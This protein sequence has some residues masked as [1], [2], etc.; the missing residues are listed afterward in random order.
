M[1]DRAA[2]PRPTANVRAEEAVIGKIIGSAESYWAIAGLLNAE[3]FTGEHHRQIFNAV[4][5]CCDT[6]SGPSMS[7]LEAWLPVSWEGVGEVEPVLQILLEKAA[8]VGSATDFVDEILAAWRERERI[9]IGK[10]ANQPAKTFEETR[11]A[12]EARF[13]V[14]D[15]S[16]RAKHA[17]HVGESADG[18]LRKSAEAYQHK[19]RRT[20]GV[21]TGIPEIDKMIGPLPPGTVVTL[22]AQSGHG[23]SALLAQILRNNAAPSLD[24]SS[25]HPSLFLSMEMSRDQNGYRN[26]SSM[27]GV[28]V[29]KQIKGDFNEK[30][31][32]DLMRAKKSL[33]QMP[34]YIQD[35][36]R[37]TVRQIGAECRAAHRR[38]GIGLFGIDHLRLVE[39][40]R[41]HWT[42]IRTIEY[43]T[44]YTKD[45]A[46][47][48]NAVIFQLAQ[49]T[50]EDSKTGNW[51]F[52]DSAI[53]GGGMVKANSD[54]VI[55]LA[56]PI[57]WLRQ[58]QPE[59]P[60]DANPKGRE[61]FDKWLKD[62]ETWRDKAEVAALK[63]R[64]GPSGSWKELEFHG[65]RMMFGDLERE[66][67]PF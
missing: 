30:E 45:L 64:D 52:K 44:A 36:G 5:K 12:I 55:G 27:T 15:D 60:S 17:V 1:N 51:R 32:E 31:Y 22:G 34:I 3:H 56:L 9:V 2:P 10:I 41:E 67:I 7:L 54:V 39:P 42:E 18:A 21:E 11:E 25:I 8:D 14:I 46:K 28:S 53:Y 19:G 35:G 33:D 23:K 24:A 49:L 40:E 6:G 65:A 16:D 47:E 29:R 66:D 20:V 62:M 48:L 26:L 58:N 43:A 38:L 61:I 63:V 59:P 50:R 37:M 4:A 57:E 13:R